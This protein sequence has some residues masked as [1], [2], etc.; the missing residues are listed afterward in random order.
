MRRLRH[1]GSGSEAARASHLYGA[2]RRREGATWTRPDGT[3][4][5]GK[6]SAWVAQG[7]RIA[8]RCVLWG[9]YASAPTMIVAEGIETGAALAYS[10]AAEIEAGAIAVA[11]AISAPGVK[12]F[13]PWAGTRRVLIAADRDEA[14]RPAVRQAR[15]LARLRRRNWR[16]GSARRCRLRSYCPGRPG[17]SVD[18]LDIL[19]REKRS[20]V[21]NGVRRTPRHS[22]N[23]PAPWT[24][25][26]PSA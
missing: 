11:A 26:L 15:A 6:K 17:E 25:V 19:R 7:D 8:G 18:W 24:P 12:Q 3:L 22:H 21:A 13:Q 1:V 4:R 9:A 20:S 14:R 23:D 10:H 5:E 16:S 2:G